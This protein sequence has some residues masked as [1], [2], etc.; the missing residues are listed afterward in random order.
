MTQTQGIVLGCGPSGGVPS[1][2]WGFGACDPENPKNVR[3]RTSFYIQAPWGKWLIDAS[4][5]M[6]AQCLAHGIDH[7]DGILCTHAHFDHIGGM[8]D[9]MAFA[10]GAPVP[11]YADACTINALENTFS[12]ACLGKHRFI[13]LHHISDTFV[14]GGQN[15]RAF[16]QEHGATHS[17]GFRFDTWAY[18][19]DLVYLSEEAFEVLSGIETWIVACLSTAPN[20]KHAHLDLVLSWV[21]RIQPKRTILIHMNTDL[22]YE[23]LKQT[24]PDGVEPAYDGMRITL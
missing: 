22:D 6:R 19:T 12:Y 11:V 13:E 18:S 5:D 20:A 2:R 21:E 17:T 15:V 1:L 3:T 14:V 16:R 7:V 9:V 8:G 10:R 4:P 23:V 24:L